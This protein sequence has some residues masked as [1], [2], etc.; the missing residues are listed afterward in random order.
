MTRWCFPGLLQHSCPLPEL[1]VLGQLFLMKAMGYLVVAE[2]K[3]AEYQGHLCTGARWPRCLVK[4]PVWLKNQLCSKAFGSQAPDF[5]LFIPLCGFVGCTWLL[6]NETR[7]GG[8][9]PRVGEQRVVPG[10]TSGAVSHLQPRAP[11]RESTGTPTRVGAI[12]GVSPGEGSLGSLGCVW[13]LSGQV[14]ELCCPCARCR[15]C[16]ILPRALSPCHKAALI[17]PNSGSLPGNSLPSHHNRDSVCRHTLCWDII[18]AIALLSK[19]CSQIHSCGKRNW[20]IFNSW[21][22]WAHQQTFNEYQAAVLLLQGCSN[23]GLPRGHSGSQT[24]VEK[25]V[26]ATREWSKVGKKEKTG[27]RSPCCVFRKEL[28]GIQHRET[29]GSKWSFL[30]AGASLAGLVINLYF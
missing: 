8:H 3:A 4:V 2:V 29:V 11:S 5:Q 22:V 7:P 17:S 23:T 18:G 12:V 21:R 27:A 16:R 9:D 30:Y 1:Q 26:C 25:W 20:W 14:P 6:K 24:C 19:Y 28:A 15:V 10:F 13:E